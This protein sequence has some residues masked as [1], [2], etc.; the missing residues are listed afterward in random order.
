MK[1]QERTAEI[2]KRAYEYARSG[3]H[4]NYIS[5]EHQLESEGL[6][7]AKIVLDAEHIHDELNALCKEHR[8]L[9]NWE[10]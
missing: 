2:L 7:G 3:K 4:L 8:K 6:S 10:A 5:I 9:S 1:K